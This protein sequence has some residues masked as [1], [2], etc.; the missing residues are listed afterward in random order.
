MLVSAIEKKPDT[1]NNTTSVQ[2]RTLKGIS[3]KVGYEKRQCSRP[4]EDNFEHKAAADIGE[5][6]RKK[7]G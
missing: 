2:N 5:Q 3:F 6:Q 1:I 4:A 7:P